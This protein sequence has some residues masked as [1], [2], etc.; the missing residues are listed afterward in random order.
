MAALQARYD[1]IKSQYDALLPSIQQIDRLARQANQLAS[2]V[3]TLNGQAAAADHDAQRRSTR[4]T[5][6][7]SRLEV[8]INQLGAGG[9]P[10]PVMIDLR[11]ALPASSS[12]QY[13][14]RALSNVRRVVVHHTATR[15]D[16]TPQQVAQF[17]VTQGLA[18]HQVPLLHQRRRDHQLGAA[19]G[20]GRCPDQC[21]GGQRRRRGGLSGR[22]L[23]RCA[24]RRGT[25]G[26]RRTDHRLAAGRPGFDPRCDRGPQRGRCLRPL[27]LARQRSGWPARP[28][29]N[30]W[31]PGCRPSSTKRPPTRTPKSS[32]CCSASANWNSGSP[33]CK[34]RPAR[35]R[36]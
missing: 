23:R 31:S 24:A 28:T 29:R 34:P 27:R 18:G 16:I 30:R 2:T 33:T 17:Q 5:W 1:S 14:T 4:W 19:S 8:E 36:R 15:S 21:R 35:C 26:S 3:T 32:G 12:K 22:Q 10:Q 25:D 6:S 9:V 7:V 11:G 13:P 20:G